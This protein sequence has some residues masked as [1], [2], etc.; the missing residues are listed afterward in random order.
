LHA[1]RVSWA[2]SEGKGQPIDA[3]T[4]KATSKTIVV[5]NPD[6]A[7]QGSVPYKYTTT[8][9]WQ[10][11]VYRPGATIHQ[12]ALAPG[13]Y[14]RPNGLA[15]LSS[16]NT[17]LMKLETAWT[18]AQQEHGLMDRPSLDADSGMVFVWPGLVDDTFYMANT[19]IPLSIAFL[20]PDG[21]VLDIQEMAA[22]DAQTLHSP[23]PS[24]CA[25]QV[26]GQCYQFA[27]EMNKGFFTNNGIQ[28][29]DKIQLTLPCSTFAGF[30]SSFVKCYS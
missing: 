1:G 24:L 13:A 8:Y 26:P 25:S 30:Q 22:E 2:L 23:D 12:P 14:P 17:V 19:E 28:V 11:S 16:G 27:I 15:H 29:G 21:K 18:L 9:A 7:H 5:S 20:G 6:S 3:S 4:F 10:G